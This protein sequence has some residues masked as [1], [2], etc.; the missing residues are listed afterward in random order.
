VLSRIRE[1][2]LEH[3]AIP[4]PRDVVIVSLVNAC[5][6]G[7]VVFSEDE[8]QQHRERIAQLARMDFVGQA[9]S[10]AVARIQ[11]ALLEVMAYSGM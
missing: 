8:L 1:V 6:L 3:D 5:D 10:Q 11:Q 7:G 2:V 4:D 9:L